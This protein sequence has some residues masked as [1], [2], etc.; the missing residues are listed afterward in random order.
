MCPHFDMAAEALGNGGSQRESDDE[1]GDEFEEEADDEADDEDDLFGAAYEDVTYR[2]ST[3]DGVEG[4]IFESGESATDFELVGEAERI[5]NR[6]SF[7]TTVAQLWKLCATASRPGDA[8]DRDAVLTGW[9]AQA[10]RNRRQLLDCWLPCSGIEFPRRTAR[11]S[12]WSNTTAGVA[13]RRRC[14]RRLSRRA[15]RRATPRG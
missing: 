4:E 6:L 13:S 14:W 10:D 3:D 9:L 15:W 5:V 2:D 12:R 1:F 11:R 7:L 8:A